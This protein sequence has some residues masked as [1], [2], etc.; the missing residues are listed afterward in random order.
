MVRHG[1]DTLGD[2]RWTLPEVGDPIAVVCADGNQLGQFFRS[3]DSLV[4]LRLGSQAIARVFKTAHDEALYRAGEPA[5]VAMV[6]GGDDLKSFLPPLPALT[7]IEA[8][9]ASV[10]REAAVI[11]VAEGTFTSDSLNRLRTLSVG[12]GLFVADAHFPASRLVGQARRL[13]HEA[14]KL[15]AKGLAKS[16]I[17]FAI[18]PTGGEIEE[19]H[20]E[21]DEGAQARSPT[22][23]VPGDRWASLVAEARAL[24]LV[25]S[26]QRAAAAEAWGLPDDEVKNRFLYQ[27]A[28]SETWKAW[29]R[30][31]GVDWRDRA[32]VCERIPDRGILALARL[33]DEARTK[34]R[35]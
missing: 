31:C 26:S 15:Y 21:N 33:F 12:I 30:E 4:A 3:L 5:Y 19:A 16:A 17:A 14:K 10:E 27:L 6:A 20:T 23:A 13:E 32:K 18:L 35:S 7:Y 34:G 22:S 11:R 28:R 8:L 25:P 29:F 24:A 2:T 1:R 9:R